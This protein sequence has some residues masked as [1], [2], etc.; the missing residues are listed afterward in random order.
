[1]TN[2]FE[3]VP[4]LEADVRWKTRSSA[5]CWRAGSCDRQMIATT[6][7]AQELLDSLGVINI[8][9]PLPPIEIGSIFYY[10]V[11]TVTQSILNVE[12]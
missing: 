5:R 9:S 6:I 8:V 3:P 2:L 7:E 11:L 4:Y 12:G 1:M 10:V